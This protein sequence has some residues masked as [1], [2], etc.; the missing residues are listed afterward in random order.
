MGEMHSMEERHSMKE[1]IRRIPLGER[2][3]RAGNGRSGGPGCGLLRK[4]LDSPVS[5]YLGSARET[6]RLCRLLPEPPKEN[7]R[8][9]YRDVAAQVCRMWGSPGERRRAAQILDILA[10][11]AVEYAVKGGNAN[12][13]A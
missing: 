10:G 8:L 7:G 13:S 2:L 1:K 6:E 11:P 12:G 3:R 4:M 9:S 5:A